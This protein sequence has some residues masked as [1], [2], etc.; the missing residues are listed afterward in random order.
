MISGPLTILALTVSLLASTESFTSALSWPSKPVQTYPLLVPVRPRATPLHA[1]APERT[2]DVAPPLQHRLFGSHRHQ[3][4]PHQHQHQHGTARLDPGAAPISPAQTAAPATTAS[5]ELPSQSPTTSTLPS[6]LRLSSKMAWL[7]GG[8]TNKALVENLWK[9]KLITTE[10]VK[11]AFLKVQSRPFDNYEMSMVDRG[12]YSR[13]MPYEDSPQ[14]IGHGATISAPHMH[15]MAI[16]SLLD[17][18][19]PR[20]GNPA[21]RVLDIG[22]GSGYLTRVIAELVGPKGT[23]V[24]VE[25][26]P[27]LRDLAEQNT[28][29]SDEG[30]RLLASGRLKFRVGD[31]R[32]GWVEPD[33][34]LRQEEMETVADRGKGWDA[35]HVGASAAE[36]H[37]ELINQ[38]RAPGRMFIPVDDSPGSERQHIWAVDKDEQGNVKRQKMIAVRYVPLRDAPARTRAKVPPLADGRAALAVVDEAAPD[39]VA[40]RGARP[41]TGAALLR[42][43]SVR[44]AAR[45]LVEAD[46]VG[47]IAAGTAASNGGEHGRG[48]AGEDGDEGG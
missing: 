22:S 37:E 46:A 6:R 18:I 28:A 32:K 11:E 8:T 30:K 35:I 48:G 7:S 2:L 39:V 40:V 23:V 20:P 42:P 9:N 10:A 27:A 5:A 16:E 21:P 24:G 15:A 38:L 36:L 13:Q 34:D 4:Q 47:S 31:G 29:K 33:E 25:H 14:P 43:S 3:Q 12:H 19:Q 45:V 44:V 17:Y 1:A 26:I 41:V